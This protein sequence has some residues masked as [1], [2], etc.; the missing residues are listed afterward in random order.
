MPAS[1]QDQE[2]EAK[3]GP[4]GIQIG[5]PLF[6][7]VSTLKGEPHTQSSELETLFN[8]MLHILSGGDL[9][10]QGKEK[11]GREQLIS[12]RYGAMHDMM[13]ESLM[14]ARVDREC[15]PALKRLRAVFFGNGEYHTGVSC[16]DFL[17]AL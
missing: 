12:M 2:Q 15:W 9:H 11:E 7:A 3:E 17:N 5:D 16:L 6:A 14:L 1:L 4:E 8:V 10:W 13:F